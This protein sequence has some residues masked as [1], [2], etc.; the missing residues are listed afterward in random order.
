MR[1]NSLYLR[2]V[3][4]PGVSDANHACPLLTS[5]SWEESLSCPLRFRPWS[6]IF[7]IYFVLAQV[8]HAPEKP[9]AAQDFR[10]ANLFDRISRSWPLAVRQCSTLPSTLHHT[11]SQFAIANH[12]CEFEEN[13][14]TS[15]Y[16]FCLN[17][18]LTLKEF[19]IIQIVCMKGNSLNYCFSYNT[20]PEQMLISLATYQKSPLCA[21]YFSP[22]ELVSF[23]SYRETPSNRS[24]YT[25]LL[26]C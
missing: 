18:L 21:P 19:W 20:L 23:E 7:V 13:F 15:I 16:S 8:I 2:T 25:K 10:E 4:L 6:S 9:V 5:I 1:W 3:F 12:N 17:L 14:F 26:C 24:S 22:A 11:L